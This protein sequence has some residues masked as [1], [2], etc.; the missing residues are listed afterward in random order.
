MSNIKEEW[1]YER[2]DTEKHY[3]YLGSVNYYL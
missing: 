1:L 2:I 3:R